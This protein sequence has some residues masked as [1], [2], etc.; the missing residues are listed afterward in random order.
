MSH[1]R[2]TAGGK[3]AEL[4]AMVSERYRDLLLSTTQIASIHDSSLKLSGALERIE[5]LCSNP[6]QV[7]NQENQNGIPEKQ[8]D[9][10]ALVIKSGKERIHPASSGKKPEATPE[11]DGSAIT[12]QLPS[13]AAVKFLLDAPEAMYR[14][15][16]ARAYLQAAFL[17]LLART[18]K[19]YML[20]T[21][22]DSFE[23]RNKVGTQSSHTYG[24]AAV[25]LL[26]SL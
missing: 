17:W 13:A 23:E 22:D 10:G 25:D 19:E 2:T 21:Q 14:L 1:N 6:A 15:L 12:E 20:S 24:F 11:T 18:V 8:E 26:V 5:A 7:L 16:S 9:E 3:Q 4:R